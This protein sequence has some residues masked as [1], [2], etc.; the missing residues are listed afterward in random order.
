MLHHHILFGVQLLFEATKQNVAIWTI[1][2][3]IWCCN[4]CYCNK[5]TVWQKPH[6]NETVDVAIESPN[7]RST[8]VSLAIE[9][10]N[11]ATTYLLWQQRVP[12]IETSMFR[13]AIERP[14]LETKYFL[15]Q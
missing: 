8:I 13:V 3:I 15:W 1:G 7:Y 10:T 11:I 12:P 4:I 6:T 5:Q 14:P 9:G 2:I